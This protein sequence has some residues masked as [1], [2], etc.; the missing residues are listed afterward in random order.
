MPPQ[1]RPSPPT[2]QPRGPFAGGASHDGDPLP[3]PIA[4]PPPEQ[5][6]HT[7]SVTQMMRRT[8]TRTNLPAAAPAPFSTEAP[9]SGRRRSTSVVG[10]IAAEAE[11]R[12]HERA[13]RSK[14][15]KGTNRALIFMFVGVTLLVFG[16]GGV[17]LMNI[18]SSTP[19]NAGGSNTGANTAVNTTVVPPP[20]GGPTPS[21]AP[22]KTPAVPVPIGPAVPPPPTPPTQPRELTPYE[23]E[24]LNRKLHPELY[25]A[26]PTP[27][28]TPAPAPVPARPTERGDLIIRLDAAAATEGGASWNRVA[29]ANAGGVTS[30]SWTAQKTEEQYPFLTFAP[31]QDLGTTA[32]LRIRYKVT[33]CSKPD[34]SVVVNDASPQL[35]I[36]HLP[37]QPGM[38]Q[39]VETEQKVTGLQGTIAEIEFRSSGDADVGMTI[40]V[41]WVE[42]YKAKEIGVT[43]VPTPASTPVPTPVPGPAGP[44][45]TVAPDPANK[46]IVVVPSKPAMPIDATQA[47]T[48]MAACE[49]G[50]VAP[51][52]KLVETNPGYLNA[53]DKNGYCPLHAAARRGKNNALRYLLS[54]GIPVDTLQK[55]GRTPLEQAAEWG[56]LDTVQLLIDNGANVNSLDDESHSILY[57]AVHGGHVD[58]VQELLRRGANANIADRKFSQTPLHAAALMGNPALLDTLLAGGA[59]PALKDSTGKTPLDL[60]TAANLRDAMAVLSR[61]ASGAVP[62]TTPAPTQPPEPIP[63]AAP[64]VKPGQEILHL[65]GTAADAPNGNWRNTTFNTEED[66]TFVNWTRPGVEE[67]PYPMF[68]VAPAAK[69]NLGAKIKIKIRLRLSEVSGPIALKLYTTLNGKHDVI[70]A[71]HEQAFP[72]AGA[73][74]QTLETTLSGTAAQL[75]TIELRVRQG[76]T[77]G[78][79]R[80]DIDSIDISGTE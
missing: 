64:A 26:T 67:A 17:V 34:I 19:P 38:T 25:P 22:I 51:L 11:N 49:K 46:V 2:G 18:G 40:S 35:N 55:F 76:G 77:G 53:R 28:P 65:H 15:G 3:L 63:G 79:S 7:S 54:V 6:V 80:I 56:H 72:N 14:S 59:N 39:W 13:E 10:G 45:A 62:G 4:P 9:P 52:Q 36:W 20:V 50:D 61:A 24:Q 27:A 68:E 57:W 43:P 71:S 29:F 30:W 69:I 58:I 60:A 41:D 44:P 70:Y 12:A 32:Y 16:V 75:Q 23:Q 42:I 37:V 74:W 1:P 33:G 21:P 8:P 66:T 47:E 31:R 5:K 48:F 78:G 73:Q